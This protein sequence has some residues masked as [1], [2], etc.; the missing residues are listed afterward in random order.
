[1][2][3]VFLSHVEEDAGVASSIAQ[4]LEEAGYSVWFYERD[5]TPGP[6]YLLQTGSAIEAS[7]VVVVLISEASM[8]SHQVTKE[9]VRAH[10]ANK[11][12]VPLL[13]EVTHAH[14]QRRQPEWREAIG[15]AASLTVHRGTPSGCLPRLLSGLQ[16]LSIS[17]GG[18]EPRKRLPDCFALGFSLVGAAAAAN[19]SSLSAQFQLCR[20]SLEEASKKLG[21]GMPDIDSPH[22]S[23]ESI[24]SQSDMIPKLRDQI[25][26]R[27]GESAA[28]AFEM[29][30]WL[31][32]SPM[33]DDEESRR[34]AIANAEG[35][36]KRTGLESGRI[37]DT[38]SILR[39]IADRN[40]FAE[41][42]T[43]SIQEI[44]KDL[45]RIGA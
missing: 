31:S 2:K 19:Q 44:L 21:L 43:R 20:R 40:A 8:G 7:D 4:G 24:L 11:P 27:F 42:V 17:P 33:S 30:I 41:Q 37:Q 14:F 15:A 25:R 38:F 28:S 34:R 6:S 9:V 45:T 32:V 16:M 13:L 23:L 18:A 29:G 5:S 3:Q 36:A 35:A 12:I 10:E 22:V 1:M 26:T 39:T